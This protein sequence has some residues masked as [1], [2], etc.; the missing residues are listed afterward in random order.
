MATVRSDSMLTLHYRLAAPDGRDWINTFG[1]RPATLTLGTQQLAP[2]LEACLVGLE[3]GASAHFELAADSAFGERDPQRVRRV[4]R[5]VLQQ[6]LADDVHIAVGD[7]LQLAGISSPSGASAGATVTAVDDDSV[8]LDFNHPLA[9]K[10]VVFDVQ[11]LGV[12]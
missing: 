8:E 9:G 12:L 11:I 4:P 10:P 3:E 7:A 6:H 1:H 5:S 2:A